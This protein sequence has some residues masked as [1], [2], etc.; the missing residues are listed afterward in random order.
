[1]IQLVNNEIV[2]AMPIRRNVHGIVRRR[3][4]SAGSRFNGN[5]ASLFP[6]AFQ[7]VQTDRG[8]LFGST[9]L[10]NTTNTSTTVL[11]LTGVIANVAV[12]IWIKSTNSASVG[13]GATFSIYYDGAGTTPAMTGV[14]PTAGVPIALTGAGSG[15]SLTWTAGT[16]VNNDT[17]KATCAGLIDQSGNGKDYFQFTASKQPVVTTGLNGKAALLFDGVDDL[18]ESTCSLPA[19]GTTPYN[20]FFLV[21]RPTTAAGAARMVA[22][23][24]GEVSAII[25]DGATQMHLYCN[26]GFGPIASGLP[27]NTWGAVE[28]LLSN[29][30]SDYLQIGSVARVTGAGAGN[31]VAPSRSISGAAVP[32]NIEFLM[33]GYVPASGFSSAAFRA[34][35]TQWAGPTVNV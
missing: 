22:D 23:G 10:A 12:P 26:G 7:V 9:P 30:A 29:S 32:A 15:L 8:F 2:R 1:M 3:C 35:I 14:T 33:G 11:A 6:T 19:P 20:G 25:L 27:T 13:A 31:G 21:R 28:F 16:S 18:L 24:A 17:W 5:F 4:A 34:A